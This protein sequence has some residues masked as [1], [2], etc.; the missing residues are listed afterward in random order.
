MSYPQ[1]GPS[2]LRDILA[3]G[4]ASLRKYCF[5]IGYLQPS[6]V[7]YT[8]PYYPVVGRYTVIALS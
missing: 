4:F 8:E 3:E 2:I 1:H 7:D 5:V 6:I